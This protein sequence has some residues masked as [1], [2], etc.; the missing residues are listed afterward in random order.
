MARRAAALAL[1]ALAAMPS[2]LPARADKAGTVP[3]ITETVPNWANPTRDRATTPPS[4]DPVPQQLQEPQPIVPEDARVTTVPGAGPGLV[5]VPIPRPKPVRL[6]AGGALPVPT[7]AGVVP[8]VTRPTGKLTIEL[9]KLGRERNPF[10]SAGLQPGAGASTWSQASV[11]DAR[12]RCAVV[13]ATMN[14]EAEPLDPIGGPDGCGIAAP[15]KISAFGAIRVRPA[16]TLNCTMAAT[17]YKW[18]TDQ[19]QPAARSTFGSPLTQ[20]S[21]FSSYACR[22]RNNGSTTRIS[23]HAFGNALDI[24]TFRMASGETVTVEGDWSSLFSIV[25]V[26]KS[27]F[28]KQIHQDACDVFATVLGPRADKAHYNHFHVDLGRGGRNKYCK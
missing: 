2:A 1:A 17:V 15:L 25:P 9:D 8:L 3:R 19:V 18:L 6:G 11:M 13:M 16:V 24:G 20:I 4:A 22:R 10:Q 5:R 23:E 27:A 26:G 14:L 12:Q 7:E 28:L 21:T